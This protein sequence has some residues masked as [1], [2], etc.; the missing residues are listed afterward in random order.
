MQMMNM[1]NGGKVEWNFFTPKKKEKILY[2]IPEKAKEENISE[3]K[4]KKWKRKN[5]CLKMYFMK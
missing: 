2:Y 5:I 4:K 1:K 3:K